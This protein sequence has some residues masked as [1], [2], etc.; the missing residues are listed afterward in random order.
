L[1]QQSLR[2]YFDLSGKN[3]TLPAQIFFFRDGVSEGE[4]EQVERFEIQA[5]QGTLIQRS[6]GLRIQVTEL[7]AEAIDET[8]QRSRTT[9]AKA[10]ITFIVVGKRCVVL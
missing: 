1:S 5:I 3:R 6:W 2:R 4:L 7:Y 8:W 10:K 9:A